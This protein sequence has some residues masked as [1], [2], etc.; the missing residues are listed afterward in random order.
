MKHK[1][2]TETFSIVEEIDGKPVTLTLTIHHDT[3]RVLHQT[4]EA[5]GMVNGT[6][7][8]NRVI[9]GM[10]GFANEFAAERIGI[11]KSQNEKKP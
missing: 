11:V 5:H 3:G 9:I 6:V 4:N 2:L 1:T 7:E 10:L 8:R